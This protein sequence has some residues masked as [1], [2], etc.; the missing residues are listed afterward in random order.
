M[1]EDGWKD[2]IIILLIVGFIFAVLIAAI[3]DGPKFCPEC[4]ARYGDNTQY[5][6]YDGCELLERRK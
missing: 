4:G 6:S 2:V 5:C 1:H 3:N